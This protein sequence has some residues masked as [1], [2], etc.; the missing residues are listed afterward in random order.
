MFFNAQIYTNIDQNCESVQY[1]VNGFSIHLFL[2]LHVSELYLC[3]SILDNGAGRR[4]LDNVPF[5][6]AECTVNN[7]EASRMDHPAAPSQIW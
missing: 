7:G 4:T 1:E 3:L 2:H 6:V 5:R